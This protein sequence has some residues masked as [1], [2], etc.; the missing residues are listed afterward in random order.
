M[1]LLLVY[2]QIR[3]NNNNNNNNNTVHV[4]NINRYN[5]NNDPNPPINS[6]HQHQLHHRANMLQRHLVLSK[7]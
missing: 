3:A 1:L 4:N 2:G 6:K 7:K 5:S